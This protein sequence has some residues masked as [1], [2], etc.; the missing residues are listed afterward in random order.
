MPGWKKNIP[1]CLQPD[2]EGATSLPSSLY[3]RKQTWKQRLKAASHEQESKNREQDGGDSSEPDV[4]L[5]QLGMRG[6]TVSFSRIFG[7]KLKP[8][9]SF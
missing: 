4:A 2:Q 3:C 6:T 1:A 7:Q 8:W 5:H 9:F